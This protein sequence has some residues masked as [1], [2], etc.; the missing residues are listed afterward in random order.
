M[1][2]RST[3]SKLKI[4]FF[5]T[6]I[7]LVIAVP[8]YLYVDSLV[9]KPAK[10]EVSGLVFDQTWVQVGTPVEISV[11]LTNIGDK[12]GNHSV[13]L[14]INDEAIVT[15][16][17]Q[18]S[19]KETTTLFFTAT[20]LSVGN[21]T[22]VIGSQTGT[23][24]VT[25]EAPTRQAELQ[26]ANLGIS[27]AK[28]GIGDPVTVSATATNIGDVS[29]E[30]SLELLVN[31][32]TRETKLLQLDAGETTTVQFDVVESAEGDYV[33]KLGTLTVSFTVTSDAQ[34]I[35][36]A[37]FQVT[38]LTINPSSVLADE[39]VEISVKVTNIGEESGS[40]TVELTVDDVVKDERTVTLAGGATEVVEF[41]VAE[42]NAGTHNVEVSTL[43]GAFTVTSSAA[44]SKDIKIRSLSVSPYEVSDGDTVTIRAKA[45]NLANEQGTLQARVLLDGVVKVTEPFVLDAGATDVPIEL[46]LTAEYVATTG[47]A[48]GFRVEV[49]N[50]GNQ[51]NTLSGYFQ[52]V[53]DGFHS[54]SVSA[55]G[56]GMKFTINGEEKSAPY[57]EL[58]PEG[59]YVVEAPDGYEGGGT[60]WNW[61][62][63]IDGPTDRVRTIDL[64]SRVSLTAN[65]MNA[66]SCPSLYVWNGKEYWYTAELSDGTGYLGIFDYFREDGSL[67]FLYSVP[68]DYTKLN[69]S[70]LEPKD[71]YYDMT[72]TQKWDEVTYVDSATLVVVEHP[73]D[74][75]VFSTKATYLYNLTEQGTIYTVS[76]NPQAP[77]S[78][79]NATG[80]DVLS[81]LSERDGISTNGN[82]FTWDTLELDLG[83]LSDAQEIKLIVAGTIIYS[84]GEEQGAWAGQFYD[85]PGEQ[86]FPP[87][88]MEVKDVEG[89]WVP[90][91]DNVQFP[92]LDVTPDCFVVNLTGVFLTED[93][94]LRINT[95]FN[96]EFDY[97]AVDTT[98]QQDI[99]VR[100]VTVSFANLTQVFTTNSTSSGNFTRYGDVTE[101]MT[102]TDDKSVI[103]RQ[104]DEITILFPEDSVSVAEGMERDYFLVASVWFKVDGLFYVSFTV[105]PM[106]FHDMSCF[107]YDLETE[108]YPYDQSHLDY[109]EEY[110]T[111][112]IAAP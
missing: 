6:L 109:L 45:D 102:T 42:T 47:K 38:E 110:N 97:I 65:Y 19:A 40:Y 67:A 48:D 1:S 27:R 105:D 69:S 17:V 58:L 32:Q 54:L 66:K 51:T 75:D 10:F 77:V 7:I 62:N 79:V 88:Y 52:V 72:I 101:L 92:L 21:H 33:V 18:L 63:W 90:V 9:P 83:D 31:D 28:A 111:R 106:P 14:T 25:S 93:Y 34:P 15:K 76:K 16:S 8:S 56:I 73:S 30:F 89:N 95:F 55:N 43:S 100:E 85:Q 107:P 78:C 53:P 60:W 112:V 2:S 81:L 5:V 39:L 87:P 80:H 24:K 57:L 41:E 94:S 20:E 23:I 108:S 49:V 26:L 22:V 96:T 84:T 46:S 61:T 59:T 74:V 36:P 82:E 91:A 98:P 11:D 70:R 50:L 12:S 29:G 44:A 35:K 86:P 64:T 71:G 104:G 13:T 68:W 3:R 99:T 103:M 4:A 37:E